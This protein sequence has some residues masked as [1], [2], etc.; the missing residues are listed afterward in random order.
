MSE[1][2]SEPEAQDPEQ[3]PESPA[4]EAQA[5][6]SSEGSDAVSAENL[7]E[8]ASAESEA[9]DTHKNDKS[10][11]KAKSAKSAKLSKAEKA[12]KRLQM[13]AAF[14]LVA[15]F[16]RVLLMAVCLA[17]L[18]VIALLWRPPEYMLNWV[19]AF[20]ENLVL[21]QVGLPLKIGRIALMEVRP[22]TQRLILENVYLYG[23]KQAHLPFVVSPYVSL[24]TDLVSY[25][26]G[27][28]QVTMIEL[29]SPQLRVIRDNEGRINFRPTFKP[30]DPN[31]PKGE[32]MDLPRAK[33]SIRDLVLLLRNESD[34]FRIS[35]YV[36][37]PFM[38]A[39]LHDSETADLY[40][41]LRTDLFTFASKSQLHV[42]SGRGWA[43]GKVASVN[44]DS[45]NQYTRGIRDLEFQSGSFA[46]ELW[47]NWDDYSMKDLRYTGELMLDHVMAE[48]PMY[49]RPV[50]ATGLLNLTEKRITLNRLQIETDGSVLRANGWLDNY[51]KVPRLDL[52][53]RSERLHIYPLLAGVQ[54]KEIKPVLAMRPQG[55]LQ[56]DIRIQGLL[57]K[58]DRL[59]YSG[60]LALPHYTMLVNNQN[61][62]VRAAHTNFVF[63]N[64]RISGD[65][66][67]GRA[68]W[69]DLDISGAHA[70][71]DYR[72]KANQ[73][74]TLV[75]INEGGWQDARLYDANATIDYSI[76]QNHLKGEVF[77]G[78]GAWQDLT[79]AS[80]RGVVDFVNNRAVGQLWLQQAA[81]QEADL[82][83]GE[84]SFV[85]T[86]QRTDATIRVASSA[87]SDAEIRSLYSSLTYT[88]QALLVRDLSALAF[89]GSIKAN[90]LIGLGP[91]QSLV[92][93]LDA[94]NLSLGQI[95]R[96]F[97]VDVPA[98]YRPDGA[99]SLQAKAWGSLADPH[100]SGRFSSPK[101][102]FPDGDQLNA[103]KDLQGQFSFTKPLATLAL[104]TNSEDAGLVKAAASLRNLDSLSA[105]L[106][107]RELPLM[108]ANNWSP[109]AYLQSGI[110]S[111]DASMNGSLRAMSRNWMDFQ[112]NAAFLAND[113][114]LR[115]PQIADG[116]TQHL[117]KADLRLTWS[118]GLADI[119]KLELVN[120][121]SRFDG[122]GK[123]SVP[124]L[125]SPNQRDHA[126]TGELTGKVDVADFPVLTAY[127]L[128]DGRIDLSLKAD[129]L[130]DGD[131]V[132]SL[133][134]QGE[135]LRFRGVSLDSFKVSTD[136]AN[137]VLK[138]HE[139]KLQQDEEELS[140]RGT[141]DF[142]PASPALDLKARAD[143]FDLQT[144]V[145][146]IPPDLRRQLEPGPEDL[147]MP[148]ADTLPDFYQLPKINERQIFRP[149]LD[150]V[151]SK[152]NDE[153]LVIS[154]KEVYDHWDRWRLEPGTE[155]Y[156][157]KNEADKRMLDTLMGQLSLNA[158]IKGSVA[159][160]D[161]AVQALIQELKL[162][163]TGVAETFLDA[164]LK[165]QKVD[166]QRFHVLEDEG[167]VLE[168][169]GD[170]NLAQNLNLEITGSGLRLKLIEPFVNNLRLSGQT[171]F[172]AVASGP[173]NNP[174]ATAELKID[175]LLVN[176]YF[177]DKLDTQALYK[178][179]YLRDTRL[180]VTVN[181]ENGPNENPTS[182]N[183]PPLRRGNT[184]NVTSGEQQVIAN[185][186]VPV[187]DLSKPMN[188]SLQLQNESFGLL[189][190]F[191]NAIDW[192]G[193]KGELLV[194][195]VGSP[196]NIQ[197][198]GQL[199]LDDAEIYVPSL[200]ESVTDL[201][202][203]ADLV[204]EPDNNKVL[205]QRVKLSSTNGNFGGGTV[206]AEGFMDLMN[207]MPSFLNLNTRMDKVTINYTQP[208]LF[209]TTTPIDTASIE[210][211]GTP[212]KPSLRGEIHIA[213]GGD[214]FF[215]FLK[216]RN[217]I[218]AT[219]SVATTAA[220]AADP[221]IFFGGLKVYVP[222]SYHLNSPL[223]DITVNSPGGINLR[224]WQRQIGIDGQIE[225]EKG[226]IY[227]LNNVL[228]VDKLN[229][230]FLRYDSKQPN[231]DVL[232][233]SFNLD[234]SFNIQG[235]SEPVNAEISGSLE[236]V[237]N[238]TMNFRF[239][240]TQG[241]TNDEI[242]RQLT[243]FNAIEGLAQGDITGVAM[244][245]SESVL[246]GLFD[247]LTSRISSLLGL[248][249]LSFGIAGQSAR[250][251]VFKF[252]VRSNPFFF[253]DEYI[254]KNLSQLEALNRIRLRATGY[255]D[256]QSS[257][258]LGAGYR[259]NEFWALDYKFEQIGSIHTVK[260]N[261]NYLL[262]F[263][264]RWADY[265]RTTYFGWEEEDGA[266]NPVPD[267]HP[268]QN[269]DDEQPDSEVP[270]SEAPTPPAGSGSSFGPSLW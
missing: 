3:E 47:A 8:N 21:D 143:D 132:A 270:E 235:A 4:P 65:V 23:H 48:V 81:W 104:R 149:D 109:E 256:E 28:P 147:P 93:N 160:P 241:L 217:D 242:L 100:A 127:N 259:I 76:K 128:T 119:Q 226:K 185:G 33:L 34:D 186:D 151:L 82:A 192:R 124:R 166:I 112:G 229:V 173:L 7:A 250:G 131:I 169:A 159:N 243:G 36:H 51:L 85:Y 265:M 136:F 5:H 37:V 67:L 79:L 172:L 223:F 247:P 187:L 90:A 126:F 46:G 139:A 168:V 87:Y 148:P 27:R 224:T 190:L 231:Q 209:E 73:V 150:A 174:S 94:K 2:P 240:N 214:I 228:T 62:D 61:V 152:L 43:T 103:F 158:D 257:Y 12:D 99:F 244:Q 201:S 59:R 86:P 120:D 183:P 141:V 135:D 114:D 111:L 84:A 49:G 200:K 96:A 125:L 44:L 69:M 63:Q 41:L 54:I 264:L 246:R 204:R 230:N 267:N 213:P 208:G 197:L 225:A 184:L 116:V 134:S 153:D 161:V 155:P 42:Y 57:N 146:L 175:D 233:A 220:T 32:P 55:I 78:S 29:G 105:R 269:A 180:Q 77:I 249:E 181:S 248:E 26:L 35:D 219:N 117:D 38:N 6:S 80:A 189:N 133:R 60:D 196:R 72:L 176:N 207:L 75:T 191:T 167:G 89:N 18:T 106:E 19:A 157:P 260:A 198:E 142:K 205:Q 15:W 236:D 68:R 171:S 88:P 211:F 252:T 107:A 258:E 17:L 53:L 144:L 97:D 92:A 101:I 22:L 74:K 245:F 263:V 195:V 14:R 71:V 262:D 162:L 216:D 194:N 165:N 227:L 179:G 215:P 164:H 45:I 218:P 40:G 50:I 11:K 9:S 222:G 221:S 24:E 261:G 206:S 1:N 83:N 202:L 237:Y 268:E 138:I 177:F 30:S 98:D 25:L 238:N 130:G 154:W 52:R 266:V 102:S 182:G 255:L 115:I 10:D 121:D 64:N 31:A 113:V 70:L 212:T 16:A 163:D 145:S 118:K 13:P 210:I 110:A 254:E 66:D 137:R 251:P 122:K 56:G 20:V 156:M 123:L 91:R 193:G 178:D 234:T 188:V 199:A 58:P 170:V 203:R 239:S 95:Q 108:T 232:R 39:D 253:I 129:T 140:V